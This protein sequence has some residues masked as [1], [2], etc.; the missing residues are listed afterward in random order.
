MDDLDRTLA[1]LAAA[2]VPAAIED[3]DACVLARIRPHA[4]ARGGAGLGIGIVAVTALA[5]GMVGAGLP[6]TAKPAAPLAP[7]GEVS[8]LAPSALLV[9]DE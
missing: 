4:P 8:P 7:L 1:R 3:I 6:A 5:I 9:G 2:P